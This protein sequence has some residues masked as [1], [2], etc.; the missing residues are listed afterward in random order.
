MRKGVFGPL[1]SIVPPTTCPAWWSWAT[2][3]DP[4]TLGVFDFANKVPGQNTLQLVDSTTFADQPIWE[5]MGTHDRNSAVINLPVTYPPE[6]LN[7]IMVTGIMTP[8][9]SADFTYPH[10][11]KSEIL[12]QFPEYQFDIN[13]R[14]LSRPAAAQAQNEITQL[15]QNTIKWLWQNDRYDLFVAVL[16]AVDRM[17]HLFWTKPQ[18]EISD[19]DGRLLLK[20]YRQMDE[21]LAYW[22]ENLSEDDYLFVISDHG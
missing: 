9:R 11:L 5:I 14:N 16:M 22:L 10:S 13:R 4:G 8:D 2:G 12:S 18:P 19:S 17:Q 15:Q 20:V 21:W 3:K 6:P 1:Q 7:G